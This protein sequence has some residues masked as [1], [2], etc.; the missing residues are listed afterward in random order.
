MCRV[1]DTLGVKE[2]C[3]QSLV[4]KHKGEGRSEDLNADGRIILIWNLKEVSWNGME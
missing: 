3:I 4:G 1:C 2:K